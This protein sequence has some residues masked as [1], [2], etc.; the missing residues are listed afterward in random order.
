MPSPLRAPI[1]SY[2]KINELAEEFLEEHEIGS[3]LPFPNSLIIRINIPPPFLASL[4]DPGK[5]SIP[6]LGYDKAVDFFSFGC[7]Y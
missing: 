7:R 4:T 5:K 3:K 1:L 6:R 2:E